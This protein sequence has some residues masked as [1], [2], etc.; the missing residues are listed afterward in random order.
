M[1]LLL[2]L[3]CT[4]PAPA[5]A[6]ASPF[7]GCV[8]DQVV[9]VKVD[10]VADWLWTAHYDDAGRIVRTDSDPGMTGHAAGAMVYDYADG[11]LVLQTW[12]GDGD[13]V[14]DLTTRTAFDGDGHGVDE[15][16]FGLDT[17]VPIGSIHRTYVDG[18]LVTE[19]RSGPTGELLNHAELDYDSRGNPVRR[20]DTAADHTSSLRSWAYDERG[21]AF[22]EALDLG[23]DG[24]TDRVQ[25][26]E[27]DALDRPTE[28]VWDNDQDGMADNFAFWSYDCPRG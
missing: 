13:G 4:P 24:V 21:N 10:G 3:A 7:A 5:V 1:I 6:A 8:V 27:Y 18:L 19:D 22:L 12:D 16:H 23:A 9:D 25:T 26:T 14:P 17:T 20:R 11:N 2:G 15:V 28:S